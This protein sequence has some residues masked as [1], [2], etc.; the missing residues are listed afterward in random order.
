MEMSHQ[1]HA[2][3]ALSYVKEPLVPIGKEV[4]WGPDTTEK[5]K[6]FP[7]LGI[8]PCHNDAL[9]L[10]GSKSSRIPDLGTRWR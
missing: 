1:L 3:A 6:P 10:Y 7:L 8:T 5:R 4:G 9:F 2:L